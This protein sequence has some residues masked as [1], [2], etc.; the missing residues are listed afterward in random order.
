MEVSNM[1]EMLLKG[2]ISRTQRTIFLVRGSLSQVPSCHLPRDEKNNDQH[3]QK[4][5][6]GTHFS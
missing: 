5:S 1:E 4:E 3:K 2:Q 6:L